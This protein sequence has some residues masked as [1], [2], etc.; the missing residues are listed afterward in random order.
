L[1]ATSSPKNSAHGIF[2]K[3]AKSPG[4]DERLCNELAKIRNGASVAPKIPNTS[5]VRDKLG[6]DLEKR[7]EPKQTEIGEN[8]ASPCNVRRL[9]RAIFMRLPCHEA[10]HGHC[11]RPW[12]NTNPPAKFDESE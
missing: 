4:R 12:G 2:K 10:H 9:Y 11:R 5:T 7:G 3:N 6:R 8:E 1:Q